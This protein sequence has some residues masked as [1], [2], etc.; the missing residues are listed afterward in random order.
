MDIL[1]CVLAQI[2]HTHKLRL[3]LGHIVTHRPHVP[4]R[5]QVGLLESDIDLLKHVLVSSGWYVFFQ[6]VYQVG[7]QQQRRYILHRLRSAIYRLQILL[8]QK[9]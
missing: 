8:Y 4:S 2:V 9:I 3:T 1:E 7:K 5:D 6:P